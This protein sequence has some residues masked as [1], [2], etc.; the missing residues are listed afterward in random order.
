M[1]SSCGFEVFRVTPECKEQL[2]SGGLFETAVP[3]ISPPDDTYFIHLQKNVTISDTRLV[4]WA[5]E[6]NRSNEFICVGGRGHKNSTKTIVRVSR[7]VRVLWVQI[8]D[9]VLAVYDKINSFE[10]RQPK[11]SLA[12]VT[13]SNCC[14]RRQ[15]SLIGTPFKTR[16]PIQTRSAQPSSRIT[17]PSPGV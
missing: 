3:V 15:S 9:E 10:S 16:E 5:S 14:G 2:R 13:P 17:K 4:S 11:R 6:H 7:W 8:C 12:F 1:Q